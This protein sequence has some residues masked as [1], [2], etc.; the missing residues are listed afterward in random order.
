MICFILKVVVFH[1]SFGGITAKKVRSMNPSEAVDTPIL[2]TRNG[3][4]L[5]HGFMKMDLK[6]NLLWI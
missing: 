4:M 2:M 1:P 6:K 3:C 5:K